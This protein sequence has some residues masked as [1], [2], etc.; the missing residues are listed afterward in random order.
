MIPFS[1]AIPASLNRAWLIV[2]ALCV[3]AL[4]LALEG[5]A[6]GQAS[7][8]YKKLELDLESRAAFQTSPTM[9]YY[10]Q[11][12]K[13]IALDR[14][15]WKQAW[16]FESNQT[17]IPK[18]ELDGS[19]LLALTWGG[20]LA[21]VDVKTGRKLW[22]V[23]ALK[24]VLTEQGL[25]G[26]DLYAQVFPSFF[27]FKNHLMV[28][29][30]GE[31]LIYKKSGSF[32]KRWFGYDSKYGFS[33]YLK[34]FEDDEYYVLKR[35]T[36]SY[37]SL[38]YPTIITNI[39]IFTNDHVMDQRSDSYKQFNKNEK[40]SNFVSFDIKRFQNYFFSSSNISNWWDVNDE[41]I[42]EGYN[43]N[44]L[45]YIYEFD[46]LKDQEE[47]L[48]R[49]PLGFGIIKS[50]YRNREWCEEKW[51]EYTE[52]PRDY[53]PI[54]ILNGNF[55]FM[56][57]MPNRRFAYY[58]IKEL[59]EKIANEYQFGDPIKDIRFTNL[60]PTSWFTELGFTNLPAGVLDSDIYIA[61][62]A[63]RSVVVSETGALRV[64]GNMRSTNLGVNARADNFIPARDLVVSDSDVIV[65]GELFVTIYQEDKK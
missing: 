65:R 33:Y 57:D 43:K 23:L 18:I 27:V 6:F 37:P 36:F 14:A 56:T 35:V 10:V 16:V 11:G 24:K 55:Y 34:A 39:E 3:A 42:R 9:L 22:S 4:L 15:T 2:L 19:Q 53:K 32:I 29:Q 60:R 17:W 48:N 44:Y 47:I 45:I 40:G 28:T 50:K 51:C 1:N 8:P 21:A 30:A 63:E 5:N 12:K 41:I 13:I 31:Y 25:Y 49:K 26:Q 46:Y 38:G 59:S 64:I 61:G 52:S 58:A 54:G 7:L 62:S 20:T